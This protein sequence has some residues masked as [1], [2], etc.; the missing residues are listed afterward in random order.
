MATDLER[1]EAELKFLQRDDRCDDGRDG[2]VELEEAI[3][4]VKRLNDVLKGSR[5][6]IREWKQN[7]AECADESQALFRTHEEAKAVWEADRER[8]N[9]QI[10][11]WQ[12]ATGSVDPESAQRRIKRLTDAL[13]AVAAADV[14]RRFHEGTATVGDLALA[15]GSLKAMAAAALD[16]VFGFGRW[17]NA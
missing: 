12:D 14:D 5:E 17:R 1:W 4:E 11:A 10:C 7:A 3:A 16:D 9:T 2:A 6:Q 13:R 15:V 8:L